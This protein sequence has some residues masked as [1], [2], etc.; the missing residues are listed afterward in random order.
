MVLAPITASLELFNYSRPFGT[1]VT[2][3][4]RTYAADKYAAGGAGRAAEDS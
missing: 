3:R 2:A 1:F 4:H